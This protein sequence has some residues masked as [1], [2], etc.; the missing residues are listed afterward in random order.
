[1]SHLRLAL[2]GAAVAVA[3]APITPATADPLP[4]PPI[5]VGQCTVNWRPLYIFS[6]DVPVTPYYPY[7][8]W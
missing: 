8:V 3:L 1:M 5:G 2:A 7:C 6:D 4:P